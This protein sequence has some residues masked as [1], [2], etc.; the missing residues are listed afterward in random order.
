[1]QHWCTSLK[2][3]NK[4]ECLHSTIT[5]V[6]VF[7]WLNCPFCKRAKALLDDVG[8]KY[9]VLELDQMGPEG[10]ALRAELAKYEHLCFQLALSIIL[11]PSCSHLPLFV[12]CS[13]RG[14]ENASG[15]LNNHRRMMHSCIVLS[16]P[17]PVYGSAVCSVHQISR[18]CHGNSYVISTVL[19][20]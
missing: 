6:M 14:D 17:S 3:T 18:T 5:Q 1:M 12:S 15:K 10:S 8:A 2:G 11:F 4:S 13:F 20:G 19:L 9:T 7:S 16:C